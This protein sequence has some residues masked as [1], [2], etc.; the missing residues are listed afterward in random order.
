MC[1]REFSR[2]ALLETGRARLSKS[3]NGLHRDRQ[4]AHTFLIGKNG[5]PVATRG[6]CGGIPRGV[7]LCR[8]MLFRGVRGAS[9]SC[10]AV[11]CDSAFRLNHRLDG[12]PSLEGLSIT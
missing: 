12:A 1:E 5:S 8:L 6:D 2:V 9:R 11:R 10:A 7:A 4:F 3:G